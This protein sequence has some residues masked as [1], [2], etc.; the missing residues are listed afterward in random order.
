MDRQRTSKAP[1]IATLV[2]IALLAG[3][4]TGIFFG[5]MVAFLKVIGDAYVRLLQM[6]VLP[7]IFVS[8]VSGLGRLTYRQAGQIALKAG[9]MLLVL[10][11]I[12]FATILLATTAYPEWQAASFFS[13]AIVESGS[14][15]DFLQLYIPANPFY[16]M[17]NTIVP[18]I[19]VFSLALGGALIAV[20]QKQTLLDLLSTISEALMRITRM[21]VW[22]APIGIFAITASAAGT[23]RT[24]EL[25]RL[26]VFVWITAVVW[27]LVIFWAL[28]LLI[29]AFTPARYREVLLRSR[30]AVVTAFATGSLLI[31]IP[32]MVDT[33]KEIIRSYTGDEEDGAELNEEDEAMVDVLVPTAFNFPTIGMIMIL[34][35]IPFAAWFHGAPLSATEFSQFI[36]I[37]LFSAFGGANISLPY[38][39]DAFALPSDL[40]QLYLIASVLI[41]R[42]SVSVGAMHVIV[43]SLMSLALMYGRF[44]ITLK[45]VAIYIALVVS[46][47]YVVLASVGFV[48][49]RTITHEYTQDQMLVGMH[50]L[51]QSVETRVHDSLPAPV[52]ASDLSHSRIEIIRSRG[53]MRV[54]YLPDRLPFAF[55]NSNGDVVGLDIA[56]AHELTRDLDVSLEL[57]RI[58]DGAT[59]VAAMNSGQIDILMTGL[60][61]TPG[62]SENFALTEPHLEQNFAFVV[63]D[64][65]RAEFSSRDIVQ[66][67]ENLRIAV[68]DQDYFVKQAQSYL[69]QAHLIRVPSPR[70]FFRGE[71]DADALAFTAEAGSAWSLIYPDYTVAIPKPTRIKFPMTYALPRGDVEFQ[72][73]VQ[74]WLE[75]KQ[76]D[77]TIVRLF[78]YW[79][80]GQT[81]A[82]SEPRWSVIRDV[83][84]WVD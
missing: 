76:R 36:G 70:M 75:L 49:D 45:R 7:Y 1:N 50:I 26:E 16:A 63:S 14:S 47:T 28:P 17:A 21:V 6:T 58:P 56:M 24:D 35:F 31:V 10:W 73:Q 68:P 29:A 78:D 52:P 77:E 13:T 32:M 11:A 12:G 80:K 81:R 53:T 67:T 44:R 25:G 3:V 41:G 15:I 79:I 83:L 84:H 22:V 57:V 23:M 62:L 60:Y 54:G 20:E 30:A 8:L 74:D 37:G 34:G 69:P 82:T 33:I 71:L 51:Q 48:I 55:R 43:L 4:A 2:I 39:L 9:T 5:E 46:V 27:L 64:H 72:S 18:A 40:F 65:R 42:M 38:L 66:N 59:A 61:I 19:V